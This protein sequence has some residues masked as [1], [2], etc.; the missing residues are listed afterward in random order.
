MSVISPRTRNTG[1]GT[2]QL[3]RI[4]LHLAGRGPNNSSL[5]PPLAAVTVVASHS[6]ARPIALRATGSHP[7]GRS[8]EKLPAH[9][10]DTFILSCPRLAHKRKMILLDKTGKNHYTT[11]RR[12]ADCIG[13]AFHP[14]SQKIDRSAGNWGGQSFLLSSSFFWEN[15]AMTSTVRRITSTIRLNRVR[16][17]VSSA[18]VSKRV[19]RHLSGLRLPASA[20]CLERHERLAGRGPNN[21][22]L[23]PPL[24]AVV[25]VALRLQGSGQGTSPKKVSSRNL[26]FVLCNNRRISD[27]GW[28]A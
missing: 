19:I 27:A 20:S 24:A 10:S 2:Q 8:S 22:S 17:N 9:W 14:A 18:R 23:L 1:C 28:K 4:R 7:S 3:L 5:F 16:T 11:N 15:F 12:G 21:S 26:C 6:I 13:P 25:V